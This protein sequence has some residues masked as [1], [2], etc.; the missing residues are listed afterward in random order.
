MHE[1][2]PRDEL[3]SIGPVLSLAAR[4]AR[5]VHP[6]LIVGQPGTG[7]TTIARHIHRAS[8][9]PGAFV[10][11][12]LASIPEELRHSEL[13]GHVEGA[14]TGAKRARV[15][16]FEAARDGTLF[17]DEIGVASQA[18]QTVFL[19]VMDDGLVRRVGEE[20]SR[21]STARL[22]AATNLD[23]VAASRQG[24]FRQDLI[25][26]FGYFVLEMPPLRARREEIL[27]LFR[28]FLSEEC[29]LLGEA[30]PEKLDVAVEEALAMAA[31]PGNLRELRSVARFVAACRDRQAASVRLADLPAAFRMRCTHLGNESRP[32][33]TA[34]KETG[35]NKTAAARQL[36]V[37]RRHLYRMLD[38]ERSQDTAQGVTGHTGK[39]PTESP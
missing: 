38:R 9:R 37:S 35:G 30:P 2:S 21:P 6:I 26:R 5:T 34:L 3:P 7:K 33:R 1:G 25:D 29:S 23:L 15:G 36:G 17:L 39:E 4:L 22:V 19:A 14:F 11:A 28:R 13:F 20:R 32:L 24:V 31:W 27:P 18:L 12:S 16:L 8:R 10:R